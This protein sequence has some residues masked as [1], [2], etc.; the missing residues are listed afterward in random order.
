MQGILA[1]PRS[2]AIDPRCRRIGIGVKAT[3]VMVEAFFCFI[4]M[5]NKK[6][7]RIMGYVSHDLLMTQFGLF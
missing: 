5:G 4:V 2:E 1:T 6:T 7:R 3:F